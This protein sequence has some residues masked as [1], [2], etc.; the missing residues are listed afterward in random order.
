MLQSNQLK[1][2]NASYSGER[3]G[4]MMIKQKN[5]IDK[6]LKMRKMKEKKEL[7]RKQKPRV[8]YLLRIAF[9]AEM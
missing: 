3:G 4:A 9:L 2:I 5:K 6:I 8:F 1:Q 7:K